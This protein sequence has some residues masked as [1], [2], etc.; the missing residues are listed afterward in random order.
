M[1]DLSSVQSSV[2]SCIETEHARLRRKQRNI[3]KKDLQAALKYGTCERSSWHSSRYKYTY[4]HIVYI[5]EASYVGSPLEVTCYAEPLILEPVP[6]SPI[7]VMRHC[8]ADLKA[9]IDP[10]TWTSN[11]VMV[12]DTSGSMR[13]SDVWGTRNR[14]D[15]VWVCAALDYLAQRLE[16]GA[17][18]GTDVISIVTM[19]EQPEVLF[20]EVPSTWVLYNKILELYNQKKVRPAGHG[21][22]LP[23]LNKAEE[24]LTR[25]SN[26]S[27][28]ASLLFL[29]DGAPS[30]VGPMG[31]ESIIAKVESLAQ[32]FGRRLTFTTIGI[33][34]KDEFGMLHKMVDA[35]KDY[36]VIAEFK[37][38]SLTSSSLGET[39]TSVAT[40]L[41]TSQTELTEL[42]TTKQRM[43][44][45]VLRE[46]RSKASQIL[47]EV[48][49]ND[50]YLYSLEQ[51][52]RKTYGEVHN[53][54]GRRVLY[55]DVPLLHPDAKY[56]ALAKGPFGEG[57]ERFAYRFFEVAAD[58]KTI[59]GKPMVAK[60]SRM[61]LE[62]IGISDAAARKDFVRNFCMT[63]QLAL[64]LAAKFNEKLKSNRRIHKNTPQVSFLD[65]SIYEIK[66]NNVG[67]CSVLVENKLD[68][69]KWQK[70]NSNN[71]MVNGKMKS[72]ESDQGT[73]QSKTSRSLEIASN[74][75]ALDLDMIEE[76]SEEEED[77]DD[78]DVEKE[79]NIRSVVFSASQVAQAFSHFSYIHSHRK[80]LVC[81]LQGVFNEEKNML[82]FS[83]PVIHYYNANRTERRNVHGRTD[84]G[85]KGI[86]DFFATH[87]C[88]EQDHLCQLVTRGF[89]R[90]ARH[91][92]SEPKSS[93]VQ[94]HSN[95]TPNM[96][97]LTDRHEPV[98]DTK[99][100]THRPL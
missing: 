9:T 62:E 37:L 97:R 82:Q 22:F 65:C 89:R 17:A 98:V 60:E 53:V 30:D 4:N 80:R 63:Q 91:H 86:D 64:R 5:V 70:W 8:T 6:V 68:H 42:G 43:V 52:T 26:S 16:S 1:S 99:K 15:S 31:K 28:A 78:D 88:K 20:R 41:T 85:E 3:D 54:D 34:S 81:D 95:R 96:H 19:G 39:F 45:E 74:L 38:P 79:V 35:A 69:N 10:N 61:I 66:D 92:R 21:Y 72:P 25:N 11:T 51:T 36:N 44:R 84:R 67:T 56:V 57:A 59:L 7:M 49:R 33:G 77:T 47:L 83:D 73:Q 76:G 29:S 40:S 71:G 13:T 27:C 12:I 75:A 100:K 87:C 50:F 48:S 46:S 58:Q 23:S 32:K 2:I 93:T 24:L 94:Q 18:T 14:L 55:D 90:A